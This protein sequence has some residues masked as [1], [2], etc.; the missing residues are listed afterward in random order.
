M[1]QAHDHRDTNSSLFS[2][3]GNESYLDNMNLPQNFQQF[4]FQPWKSV[5]SSNDDLC[6][7][8]SFVAL[9]INIVPAQRNGRYPIAQIRAVYT[10]LSTS[11]AALPLG[12]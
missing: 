1:R 3:T 2:F 4:Q 9:D 11:R 5:S 6:L 8:M 7:L 12:L 10:P